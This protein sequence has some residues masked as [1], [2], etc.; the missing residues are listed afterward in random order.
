MAKIT[1]LLR[2][3]SKTSTVQS[4][5][6]RH[7]HKGSNFV[8]A[9]GVSIDPIYFDIASGKVVP[10]H[11]D[12][13]ALNETI[14]SVYNRID[15][16]RSK[17]EKQGIEPTRAAMAEAWQIDE[18]V[19]RIVTEAQPSNERAKGMLYRDMLREQAELLEKLAAIKK[20]IQLYEVE[21]G[22]NDGRLLSVYI[23][24]YADEMEKT[25]ADNTTRIYRNLANV[26]TAFDY[27]WRVDEV[28]KVTL[29]KFEDW[30]IDSGKKNLTIKDAITKIKT[31]VYHYA[32]IL[33][34][35]PEVIT[36][37]RTHK[38]K[39]LKKRNPNVIY[40]TKNELL[41]LMAV[42]LTNKVEQRVR[43]RFVLMSLL[44]VRWSDST[45]SKADIEDGHLRITT[46]KTDTEV[47]IPISPPAMEILERY[48]FTIPVYQSQYFNIIIKKVCARVPSLNR[49]IWYKEYRGVNKAEKTEKPKYE[50]ISTHVARKTFINLALLKGINPVALAGVVGHEGTEL[51]MTTY[52]S[53]QAGKE[54]ILNLLD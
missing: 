26:V 12:A 4:I 2:E 53:K 42:E 46:E 11:P 34:V 52:G 40:L 1:F 20:K 32:D 17:L 48:N 18:N 29:A 7:S 13:P 27:E 47:M 10:K 41:D 54:V 5:T 14:S 37:L 35:K 50:T 22:Y 16:L 28:T 25:A 21:N 19:R 8:K 49:P 45:I 9:T 51:I 33:G 6:V 24:R 23:G 44:G 38:T 39:V 3:T 36:A 43:D 31:V 30:L 15:R